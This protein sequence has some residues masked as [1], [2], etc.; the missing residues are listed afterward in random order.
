MRPV[1]ACA[2]LIAMTLALAGIV[3]GQTALAQESTPAGASTGVIEIHGR[4]CEE[5]P[6]GDAWYDTCHDVPLSG[7][8]FSA[9]DTQTQESVDGATDDA[10]NI[11]LEIAPGQYEI[12]GPPDDQVEESFIYCSAGDGGPQAEYPV[13][14]DVE[15]PYL[16]CDYYVV[17]GDAQGEV[18]VDVMVN[19]CVAPGC[20]ENP[21]AVEPVDGVEVTVTS[22]DTDEELGTCVSGETEP[23][24]CRIDMSDLP[25]TVDVTV[26]EETLPDGWLADPNPQSYEVYPDRATIWV[27][28]TAEDAGETPP[29]DDG[30]G[31]PLPVPI[32]LELPA[33]LYDGTCADLDASASAEPLEPLIVVEGDP[34]GSPGAV[35]AASGYTEVA[36]TVDDFLAGQYAIAVMDE[37]Q[38]VVACGDIGGVMDQAGAISIGLVPVDGSGAVG[39]A[40]L[41]PIGDG[42]TTGITAIVIP[43]GLAPASD[44]LATPGA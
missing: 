13:T 19:L 41:V 44:S 18:P 9:I 31:V 34:G 22:Q 42:A 30:N 3:A 12:A 24:H 33:S 6:A 7:Q 26:N 43:G 14:I 11:V 2:A 37:Q 8:V 28:L 1:R 23:G 25:R 38:N 15:Q 32:A 20:N 5:I 17:P 39:T 27:L 29:P 16:V 4:L 40:H 35:T 21:D 36:L 10:G